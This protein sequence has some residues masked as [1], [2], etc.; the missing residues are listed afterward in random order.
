M[1]ITVWNEYRHEK[2][3]E[4]VRAIYPDGIHAC[5]A[6]FLTEAGFDTATATLDMPEAGGRSEL[7]RGLLRFSLFR[8]GKRG[9]G[10][11]KFL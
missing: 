3:D 5:I 10:I 2:V 6:K 4:N 7:P 9:K 8:F 11:C 1:K